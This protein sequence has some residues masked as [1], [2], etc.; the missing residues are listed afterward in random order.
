MMKIT[1]LLAVISG[2][3]VG[4]DVPHD[5]EKLHRVGRTTVSDHERRI[6]KLESLGKFQFK[7]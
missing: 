2:F 1:L 7:W 4:N 5:R 3:T 6:S